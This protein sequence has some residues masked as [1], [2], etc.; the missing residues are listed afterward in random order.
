MWLVSLQPTYTSQCMLCYAAVYLSYYTCF[1]VFAVG[2]LL[3]NTIL[4]IADR[5]TEIRVNCRRQ[6]IEK[7]NNE[8]VYLDDNTS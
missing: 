7:M 8:S 1:I 5:V 3:I 4:H 2:L 6:Q